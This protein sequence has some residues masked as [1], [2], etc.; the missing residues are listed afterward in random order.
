MFAHMPAFFQQTSYK[1]PRSARKTV[2]D[3]AHGWQGGLFTYLEAHPVQGEAFN[4]L[5][6]TTTLNRARW[7][8]IF[9]SHT[10]LDSGSGDDDP[11]SP[12]LVDIGGSVGQDLWA[13]YELHPETASRLYLE[14]L[15]SV[16]ADE[17]T[18]VLKGINKV[19]Y[20]FYT[21]QPIKR[22]FETTFAEV[23]Q[24]P[25]QKLTKPRKD[26]RAYYMH[27]ILHDWP[28]KQARKILE[29]QKAALK[30]GYSRILIH[31]QIMDDDVRSVHPHA[32]VFDISMMAFGA[33]QE[34]TE[35]EWRALVE[36]AGLSVV[37]IWRA[38]GAVQGVIEVGLR[39]GAKL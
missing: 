11:S 7:T 16:L 3:S 36:S 34:R 12:L 37:K 9:P 30:P 2:F 38:P 35:K 26:A 29:I 18:S 23:V 39:E 31:D 15:P 33:A 6:R 24:V 17:K 19:A 10:L 8:S 5:Q 13:F 22:T 21:P 14:D 4:T 28:D 1:N 25:Q 32:A 20:D 27:H